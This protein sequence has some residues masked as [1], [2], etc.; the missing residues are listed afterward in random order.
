MLDG[1]VVV[2]AD[3]LAGN[4]RR[5]TQGVYFGLDEAEYHADPSLG[6]TDIRRLRNV[7]YDWWWHSAYNPLR[8]K[9]GDDYQI[10]RKGDGRPVGKAI[11]SLV[12]YGA[13]AFEMA[14]VRRPEHIKKMTEKLA[15][16]I[17]P[18]GQMI[19]HADDYD[20]AVIAAATICAN[21]ALRNAFSGGF[22]EVSVFWVGE[23]EGRRIPMKARLDYMRPRATVDLK[24]IRNSRDLP[25]VEASRRRIAE[26]RYD[27]QAEHYNTGRRAARALVALDAVYDCP[28][29]ALLKRIVAIDEWA[30]VIVFFQADDA[31]LTWA[32]SL[33]PLNQILTIANANAAQ[34]L[35]NY[36][37]CAERFGFDNPWLISEPVEEI[38]INDLP[39]WAWR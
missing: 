23:F 2:S 6:S 32:T 35:A 16:T 9:N 4:L 38:D 34:A 20:R 31:P 13:D 11:H 3:V 36:V 5:H 8:P 10:V 39:T 15:A 30:Y 33:S 22:S 18:A 29:T 24:S 26:A 28:D 17:A 25:F 21:P 19:L 7:P 1:N 27:I 12:L 37:A 14:Y